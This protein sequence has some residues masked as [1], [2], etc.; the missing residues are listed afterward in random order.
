MRGWGASGSSSV[1]N[2]AVLAQVGIIKFTKFFAATTAP[3]TAFT[4]TTV[5]AT[6]GA[7]AATTA[8]FP[9]TKKPNVD[10]L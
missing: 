3:T 9:M 10:P 4:T 5:A 7:A 1:N 8:P 6:T 2:S